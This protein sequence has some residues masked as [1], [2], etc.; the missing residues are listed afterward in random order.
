MTANTPETNAEQ[1]PVAQET[2]APD[3]GIKS[4]LTDAQKEM[5][6][7]KSRGGAGASWQSTGKG[8]KPTQAS[9]KQA[10]SEKKVRW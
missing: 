3:A 5:L 9:G 7:S 6:A 8:H 4:K 2:D 10:K 1:E